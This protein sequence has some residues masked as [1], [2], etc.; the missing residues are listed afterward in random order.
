MSK[1]TWIK[2]ERGGQVSRTTRRAAAVALGWPIDAADRLVGGVDPEDLGTVPS[3]EPI[4]RVEAL[5][6]VEQ[7]MHRTD[8]DPESVEIALALLTKI[9][10]F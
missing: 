7:T 10:E 6:I 2:L 9:M 3:Q 4:T 1:P 8:L 5:G